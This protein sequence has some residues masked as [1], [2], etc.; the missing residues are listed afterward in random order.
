MLFRSYVDDP[1]AIPVLMSDAAMRRKQADDKIK[2]LRKEKENNENRVNEISGELKTAPEE[3]ESKLVPQEEEELIG[4][5]ENEISEKKEQLLKEL[6]EKD[7]ETEKADERYAQLTASSAETE[8]A[9]IANQ[10]EIKKLNEKYEAKKAD[11]EV[12]RASKAELEAAKIGRASCR[13]RVYVL[14]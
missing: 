11:Y 4:K 5:E 7:P 8:N 12:Y 2:N 14:V 13:E 10:E 9:L 6:D 3:L 1:S